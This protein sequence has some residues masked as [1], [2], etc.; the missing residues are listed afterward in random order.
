MSIK[1]FALYMHQHAHIDMYE[2]DI[3]MRW[4]LTGLK[5]YLAQYLYYKRAP[6]VYA[7]NTY[8]VM[9]LKVLRASGVQLLTPSCNL[10][11][12]I[13]KVSLSI[14]EA[15]AHMRAFTVA[16]PSSSVEVLRVFDS[17]VLRSIRKGW[18]GSTLCIQIC[19]EAHM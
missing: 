18:S 12:S 2:R 3:Q 7:C 5:L 16:S 19:T 4:K 1:P 6:Y 14:L 9:L 15:R 10:A 8:I 13:F 17:M 11:S